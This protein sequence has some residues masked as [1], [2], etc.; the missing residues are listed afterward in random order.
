MYE[1]LKITTLKI[2]VFCSSSNNKRHYE[3]YFQFHINYVSNTFAIPPFFL[4]S[5]LL[6]IWLNNHNLIIVIP[7][8][9][10][11]YISQLLRIFLLFFT[12]YSY[13]FTT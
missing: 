2:T 10:T 3:A 11:W 4:F 7:Y 5:V 12:F 6:D 1:I 9:K 13:I 8:D